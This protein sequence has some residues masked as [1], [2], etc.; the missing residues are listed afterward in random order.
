MGR[1]ATVMVGEGMD[2][3]KVGYCDGRVGHEL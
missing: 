2:C 1:W 3:E